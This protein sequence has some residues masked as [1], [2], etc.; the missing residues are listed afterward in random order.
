MATSMAESACS[1]LSTPVSQEESPPS[2]IANSVRNLA[3]T[4]KSSHVPV[5][6]RQAGKMIQGQCFVQ[7]YY[8]KESVESLPKKTSSYREMPNWTSDEYQALVSFLLLYTNGSSWSSCARKN[9][10]EVLG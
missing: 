7:G 10:V 6:F 2:S 8:R 4:P 9:T 3:L 1:E 5:S